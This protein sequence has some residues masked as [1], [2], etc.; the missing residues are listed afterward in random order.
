M[1]YICGSTH[2]LDGL[3]AEELHRLAGALNVHLDLRQMSMRTFTKVCEV[4]SRFPDLVMGLF[5]LLEHVAGI[6][7]LDQRLVLLPLAV[8]RRVAPVSVGGQVSLS[9]LDQ[10][11]PRIHSH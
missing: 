4:S 10:P 5:V 1:E 3:A 11:L 7:L 9:R 8:Q 2:L 6:V